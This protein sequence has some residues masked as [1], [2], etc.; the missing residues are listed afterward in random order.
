[1]YQTHP[2]IHDIVATLTRRTHDNSSARDAYQEVFKKHNCKYIASGAF[3]SVYEHPDSDKVIKISTQR[4]AYYMFARWCMLPA[5]RNN[6]HLPEVYEEKMVKTRN[7]FMFIHV[8]EKLVVPKSLRT[9]NRTPEVP[10]DCP[11]V[12][13]GTMWGVVRKMTRSQGWTRGEFATAYPTRLSFMREILKRSKQRHKDDPFDFP[14]VL[15]IIDLRRHQLFVNTMYELFIKFAD[16]ANLDFHGGNIM[17]RKGKRY[18]SRR[19]GTI[20]ITDPVSEI[21]SSYREDMKKP[22]TYSAIQYTTVATHVLNDFTTKVKPIE[23]NVPDV[24]Y[25]FTD[26][27]EYNEA[28]SLNSFYQR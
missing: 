20:V 18:N 25:T 12:I 8:I 28:V 17:L 27:R 19:S 5:Q 15:K 2:V 7:G 23:I 24:S 13:I 3:G 6:P 1:M 11:D 16:I 10:S 4:D 14:Y 26:E 22:I 21:Y 9:E